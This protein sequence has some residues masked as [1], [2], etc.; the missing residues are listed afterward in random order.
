MT[1]HVDNDKLTTLLLVTIWCTCQ[2]RPSY[3]TK[4]F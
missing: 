4:H 1:I 3:V 2:F